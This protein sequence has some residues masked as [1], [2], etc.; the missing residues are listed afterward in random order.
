M[1][2]KS[3]RIALSRAFEVKREVSLDLVKQQLKSFQ[4]VFDAYSSLCFFL[5]SFIGLSCYHCSPSLL[6]TGD[7]ICGACEKL[8]LSRRVSKVDAYCAS[9]YASIMVI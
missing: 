5:Q 4:V 1:H 7:F 3:S 2:W 6:C 8:S 9:V